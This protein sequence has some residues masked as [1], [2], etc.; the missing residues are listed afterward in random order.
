MSEYVLVVNSTIMSLH[1]KAGTAFA[2]AMPACPIANRPCFASLKKASCARPLIIT[3]ASEDKEGETTSVR[4]ALKAAE[5]RQAQR[6]PSGNRSADSTDWISSQLTRRFGI[7]GGLAWLGFLTFGAVSEQIKT[8][9]EVASEEAG[10]KVT[11]VMVM[12]LYDDAWLV[13][14]VL[15][16]CVY[17]RPGSFGDFG[18][19]LLRTAHAAVENCTLPRHHFYAGNKGSQGGHHPLRGS[20]HRC[21]G[22]RRSTV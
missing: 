15:F 7:A 18:G 5:Q 2:T 16:F 19:L 10:R 4:E 17:W 9:L 11:V 22:G 8:R 12:G 21:G 13:V 1:V 20:L 14:A 3:R 6:Q